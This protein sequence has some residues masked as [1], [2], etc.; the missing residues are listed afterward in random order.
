M[1][2]TGRHSSYTSGFHSGFFL[3][4]EE[5][6]EAPAHPPPSP[7]E[8]YYLETSEI[9]F[10]AYFDRKLVLT[11]SWLKYT[12]PLNKCGISACRLV[13]LSS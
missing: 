3:L 6:I 10:Q 11:V 2:T 7:R 1:C 9:A 4:G 8:K 12:Y 5:R 13:V